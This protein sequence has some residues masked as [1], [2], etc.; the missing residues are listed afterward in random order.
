MNDT[1]VHFYIQSC[2]TFDSAFRQ[3]RCCNWWATGE[4]V[5]G[6]ASVGPSY[7][8]QDLGSLT[9]P[10]LQVHTNDTNVFFFFN[11]NTP[12]MCFS[13]KAG[14]MSVCVSRDRW[15]C[16]LWITCWPVISGHRT[17]FSLT[18]KNLLLT[19]WQRPTSFWDW[20]MMGH[21]CTQWGTRLSYNTLSFHIMWTAVCMNGF[22]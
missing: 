21:C 10:C 8:S 4:K 9:R 22:E 12:L 13:V 5:Y 6:E 17:P 2:D 1:I 3:G 19:T 7:S 15:R 20:R 14:R 16:Y 11:R 18:A